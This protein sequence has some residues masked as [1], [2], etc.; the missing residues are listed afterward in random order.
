MTPLRTAQEGTALH[1]FIL[2]LVLLACIRFGC[3]LN[4]CNNIRGM[5]AA[6]SFGVFCTVE[7]YED[8]SCQAMMNSKCPAQQSVGDLSHG[9]AQVTEKYDKRKSLT[10]FPSL[11]TFSAKYRLQSTAIA[12]ANDLPCLVLSRQSSM[13]FWRRDGQLLIRSRVAHPDTCLSQ[14]HFLASPVFASLIK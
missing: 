1:W 10:T 6:R 9:L 3:F 12:D 2:T 11:R 8:L 4:T 5:H 7:I 14:Q 13:P